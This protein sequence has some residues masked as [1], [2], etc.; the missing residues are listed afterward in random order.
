MKTGDLIF[1]HYAVRVSVVHHLTKGSDRYWVSFDRNDPFA[2]HRYMD[3]E[4]WTPIVI[5]D[6]HPAFDPQGAVQVYALP[7]GKCLVKK[8]ELTQRWDSNRVI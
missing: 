8:T 1:R 2:V 7:L 4:P 6:P 3:L 5:L